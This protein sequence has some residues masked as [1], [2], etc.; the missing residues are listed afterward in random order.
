MPGRVCRSARR[1]VTSSRSSES[2]EGGA[3]MKPLV[4]IVS[5]GGKTD[6][7][8]LTVLV[9]MM[10]LTLSPVSMAKPRKTVRHLPYRAPTTN[11][12]DPPTPANQQHL[13]PGRPLC[14]DGGYRIRPCSMGGG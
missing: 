11:Q 14:D 8:K 6:V 4:A 1:G 13:W 3:L 5:R 10:L 12:Q 9:L 7:H 2:G